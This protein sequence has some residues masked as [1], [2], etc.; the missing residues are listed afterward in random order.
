MTSESSLPPGKM[1]TGEHL[2]GGAGENKPLI[3]L[4]LGGLNQFEPAPPPFEGSDDFPQQSFAVIFR[5]ISVWHLLSRSAI[6]ILSGYSDRQVYRALVHLERRRLVRSIG[7]IGPKIYVLGPA[8]PKVSIPLVVGRHI[9]YSSPR[10]RFSTSA[11]T[12]GKKIKVAE[13]PYYVAEAAAWIYSKIVA[14]NGRCLVYPESILRAFFGWYPPSAPTDESARRWY[15]TS[16]PDALF[17]VGPASFRFELQLSRVPP[18]DYV[19]TTSHFPSHQASRRLCWSDG[20]TYLASGPKGPLGLNAVLL[21]P[22]GSSRVL[23]RRS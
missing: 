12:T 10:G 15:A 5:L 21:R 16:M 11:L 14:A 4:I 7:R 8:D 1:P 2:P 13:H 23:P 17:H 22:D 18:A 3:D 19:T 6:L 9:F 20:I